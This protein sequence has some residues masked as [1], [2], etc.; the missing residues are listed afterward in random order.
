MIKK[1]IFFGLR[2]AASVALMLAL[3][4]LYRLWLDGFDLKSDPAFWPLLFQWSVLLPI[5][6]VVGM[7]AGVVFDLLSTRAG[8]SIEHWADSRP[9]MPGRKLTDQSEKAS[10]EA[11]SPNVR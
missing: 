1:A 5:G 2:L 10:P 9:F 7:L 4:G 11:D 3:G 6:L 8:R